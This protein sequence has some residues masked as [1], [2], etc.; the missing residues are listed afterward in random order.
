MSGQTTLEREISKLEAYTDL[1]VDFEI[2][3]N[4][5]M[6][7]SLKVESHRRALIDRWVVKSLMSDVD[8]EVNHY[9]K[10][11]D[12]SEQAK[13]DL[14]NID[15]DNIEDIMDDEDDVDDEEEN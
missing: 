10:D 5:R 8:D 9:S 6:F 14:E 12:Y 11:E 7:I 4:R 13:D 2:L 3:F 1:S 15:D